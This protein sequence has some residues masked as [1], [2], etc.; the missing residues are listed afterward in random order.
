MASPFAAFA[1]STLRFEV[2]TGDLVN[3]ANGNL[4]P[5]T[6]VLEATAVLQQ[7]RAPDRESR[8]GV[9]SSA[10]WLEGFLIAPS[11]LPGLVTPDSPCACVWQGRQGR[12]F[13][14]LTASNA[15]LAALRI[16]TIE[17]L[18]GYFQP[19]SF[20][21]EGPP[22]T[23]SPPPQNGQFTE[24]LPAAVSLSAL[25]LAAVNA[26]GQLV[27]ASSANPEHAYALLGLLLQAV[28]A[29]Q[30]TR[31]LVEGP[32]SDPSWNWTVGQPIFLGENGL[33][34]QTPPETGFLLRVALPVSPTQIQIDFDN[35][36]FLD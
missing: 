25:R 11:P 34:A 9:D 35:P 23:P 6:A 22:W 2:A 10:I 4:R 14:E 29:G 12:F 20:V 21:V 36:I 3:D 26:S 15:Y 17:R 24:S 27:Y 33:L 7:K 18:R 16:T 1:N 30:T 5:A 13:L 32:A 31:L 8:P 28:S 19:G